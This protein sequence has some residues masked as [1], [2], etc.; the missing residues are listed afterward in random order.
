MEKLSHKS[1]GE[2][3]QSVKSGKTGKSIK[4]GRSGSKNK[5]INILSLQDEDKL[6]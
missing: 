1:G 3:V 5:Q 2:D 4:S 6:F